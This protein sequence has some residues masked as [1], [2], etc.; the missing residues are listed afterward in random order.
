[1]THRESRAQRWARRVARFFGPT[2][3]SRQVGSNEH[4]L[5]FVLPYAE[6][7]PREAKRPDSSSFLGSGRLS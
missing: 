4:V 6:G 3:P 2:D 7:Q 1:M 5:I